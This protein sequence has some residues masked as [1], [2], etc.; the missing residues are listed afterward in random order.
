[1]TLAPLVGLLFGVPTAALVRVAHEIDSSAPVTAVL[2]VGLLALLTRAMH[3]DGLAD[4]ADGLG[5]GRPPE[6]ALAIMRQSDIGPFGVATLVLV[7]MLQVAALSDLVTHHD[8][9]A[10]LVTGLVASRLALPMSCSRGIAAARTDGLGHAVAG[11]VRP[12]QLVLSAAVSAVVVGTALIACF[13]PV[14]RATRV[15]PATSLRED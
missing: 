8:A 13:L 6:Q 14:R 1:M 2:V 12:L 15:D 10:G 4:T 7:L 11:S 3:L 5:S 9:G